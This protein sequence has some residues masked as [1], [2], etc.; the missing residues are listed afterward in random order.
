LS[1]EHG[2]FSPNS[3]RVRIVLDDALKVKFLAWQY[4]F[5]IG[6]RNLKT[7]WKFKI[8]RRWRSTLW[9]RAWNYH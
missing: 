5:S 7:S 9:G 6:W 4:A 2:F 3:L 8:E 1:L